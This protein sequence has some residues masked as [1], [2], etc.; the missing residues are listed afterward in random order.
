MEKVIFTKACLEFI[1]KEGKI[2]EVQDLINISQGAEQKV[3]ER[4]EKVIE[5][6]V[7]N[8]K[9]DLNEDK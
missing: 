2:Q 6:M 4:G 7:V 8:F 3:L 9:E 5:Y 1:A